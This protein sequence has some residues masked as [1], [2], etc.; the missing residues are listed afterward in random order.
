MRKN[1]QVKIRPRWEYGIF[2][3]VRRRGCGIAV[4]TLLSFILELI[5]APK[6]MP[7]YAVINDSYAQSDIHIPCNGDDLSRFLSH[8]TSGALRT[9]IHGIDALGEERYVESCC[10]EQM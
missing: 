1:K 6:Q 7:C 10:I 9:C 3:G 5:P 4:S 8:M 2:V